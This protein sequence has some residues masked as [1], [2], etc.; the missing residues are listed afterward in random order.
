MDLPTKI[1]EQIAFNSRFKIEEHMLIVMK[2]ST[3][4]KY[5]SQP[6]Q[7][8]NKQIKIAIKFLTMF[9][10]IFNITNSNNKFH[11]KKSITNEDDFIQ[12]NIVPGAYEIEN[13]HNEIK[14]I[15]TD[16]GYYTE[17]E[18]L[19]TIKPNFSTLGSIIEISPTGPIISFV[20]EDSIRNLLGFNETILYK[21]N[22]PSPNPVVII[23]FDNVFIETDIA[24]GMLF[25][26][27]RTG[28]IR[29]ITMAVS[30]GYKFINKF[31]GGVQWYMMENNDIISSICFNLKKRK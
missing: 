10:G 19:F 4:E 5:L 27:K 23:S 25:R 15:I 17:D 28:M 3:H 6:L 11:F 9:N 18:Y 30:P 7:T 29:K 8:N 20:F 26:G 14:R 13:L 24:H 21:E 1:L 2:E 12:I 16:K 31:H 22:I